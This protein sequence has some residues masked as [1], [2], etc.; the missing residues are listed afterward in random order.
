[1]DSDERSSS[2]P[3]FEN[4]FGSASCVCKGLVVGENCGARGDRRKVL[5]DYLFR[6]EVVD[7]HEIAYFRRP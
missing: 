4:A 6:V 5:D 7:D 3:G 2:N 1:M